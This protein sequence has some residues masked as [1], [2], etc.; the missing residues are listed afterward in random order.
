MPQL[1]TC[2]LALTMTVTLGAQSATKRLDLTI[3]GSARAEEST[4][5]KG[6]G[7]IVSKPQP[8]P[9]RLTLEK[10]D[11]EAYHRADALVFEVLLENTGDRAIRLPWS[12]R[13][14]V[15][16]ERAEAGIVRGLLFLR[17]L[18][19]KGT[20][21]QGPGIVLAGLR[22]GDTS[23]VLQPREQASI[24]VPARWSSLSPQTVKW[25]EGAD[26]TPLRLIATFRLNDGPTS[27]ATITSVNQLEIS[28]NMDT[29][30][31]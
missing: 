18:D 24:V 12:R 4:S 26:R 14:D 23:M 28:L 15:V 16:A 2:L 3:P 25:L 19:E 9:L 8:L 30:N 21:H 31:R 20:Q 29:T 17:F 5:M 11:R 10:L 22:T 6:S 13:N 1:S 7:G 27:Y